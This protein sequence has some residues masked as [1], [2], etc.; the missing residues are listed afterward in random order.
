MVNESPPPATSKSVLRFACSCA[1]AAPVADDPWVAIAKQ[2]KLNDGTKERILN[3]INRQPRTISQLAEELGL[4]APSVHRQVAELLASELIREVDVDAG[5]RRSSV[6][7]YYRP[8]FLVVRAADRQALDPVI[9]E[10]ANAFAAAF[11][12]RLPRLAETMV[13]AGSVDG[14]HEAETLPHYLYAAAVRQ[15]REKLE[16]ESSLPPWSEHADGSRWLWWAEEAF[17]PEHG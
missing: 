13:A 15:A 10:V 6:E 1:S 12:E 16:A 5:R 2:G 14:A 11:R 3:S 7:R 8:G 9:E 17:E 4:S